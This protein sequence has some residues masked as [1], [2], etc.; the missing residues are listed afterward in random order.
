M[1]EWLQNIYNIVESIDLIEGFSSIMI[2]A[3]SGLMGVSRCQVSEAI[4]LKKG[5]N[6]R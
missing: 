6:F 1:E 4:F 5:L 2:L 3:N